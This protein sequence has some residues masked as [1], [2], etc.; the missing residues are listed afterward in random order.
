MKLILKGNDARYAVEQSLLA[1]FPQER[2]VYDPAA[3]EENE[4]VITVSDTG[5]GIPPEDLDRVFERFSFL[6]LSPVSAPFRSAQSASGSAKP[7]RMALMA[8]AYSR[9]FRSSSQATSLGC[10]MS[11]LTLKLE[12]LH[13]PEQ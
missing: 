3:E 11:P 6:P 9:R 12:A 5:I 1:F 2:P 13:P 4:A 10:M 8:M 7:E